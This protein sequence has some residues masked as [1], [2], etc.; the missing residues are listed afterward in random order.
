MNVRHAI[1]LS[2]G[3]GSRL[4]PLTLEV[5]KCLVRVGGKS[6][7]R[8][9]LDAL[10]TA[11]VETFTIITGYRAEQIE[12]ATALLCDDGIAIATLY[13]PFWQ[14][15]SS[16]GSVWVAREQ[17][18]QPFILLNGDT[19]FDPALLAEALKRACAGVNLLVEKAHKPEE[20][21]MRVEL[22]GGIVREVAKG[23]P[24]S[25]AEY[26]SLGVVVSRDPYGENYLS[27]L[28]RVLRSPSGANRFHH[29]VVDDVAHRTGVGA[30]EVG[31]G[32]WQEIDRPEDIE[33]WNQLH[34]QPIDS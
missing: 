11:G 17:L 28:E 18:R 32:F 2:A 29:A 25:R 22:A 9:Q 8:H 4:L 27:A 26:R 24:L 13:N 34:H 16:I 5:P 23:L 31:R 21:D 30:I 33:R 1:I 3:Q 19:I 15:A 10:L 20:D 7:L 6:I 12:S 14:A